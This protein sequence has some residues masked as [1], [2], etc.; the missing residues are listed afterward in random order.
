M[1]LK[2]QN[3]CIKLIVFYPG[4]S[5]AWIM[6]KRPSIAYDLSCCTYFNHVEHVSWVALFWRRSHQLLIVFVNKVALHCSI[7]TPYHIDAFMIEFLPSSC[8]AKWLVTWA[9]MDA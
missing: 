3:D 9:K 2:I 7:A 8:V 5:P 4:G 6:P 1:E